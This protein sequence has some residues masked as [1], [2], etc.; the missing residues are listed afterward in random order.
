MNNINKIFLTILLSISGI[1]LAT[2]QNSVTVSSAEGVPGTVVNIDVMLQNSDG[3]TAAEFVFPLAEKQLVYVDGSCEINAE[4]A[5]GH[6]ISAATVDGNLKVYV[7]GFS[8]KQLKENDGRLFSFSLKLGKS[9]ALYPLQPQVIL[10]DAQGEALPVTANEGDV[11]I[12]APQA[13]IVTQTIDFGHV[14]IRSQYEKTLTLRNCGTTAL[15]V[16]DIVTSSDVFSVSERAFTIPAGG[17]K[18]LNVLFAPVKRGAVEETVTV[19]SNAVNGS[20]TARLVADPYSVNELH[21]SAASGIAGEEVTVEL[22]MN[23]MEPIVGLQT[24]FTIP[25]QLEFVEGSFAPTERASSHTASATCSSGKV[26]LLLYS[27]NNNAISGNDGVVATFRL[28][29]AGHSGYYRIAPENTVLSNVALENMTSAVSGNDIRISSPAIDGNSEL[30]MGSTPVTEVARAEY[31]VKNSGSAPLV[32]SSVA[33][34]A[35]GYKV[36]NELP[37]TI[38][39]YSSGTLNV[40]YT[41]AKEGEHSV[42]MNIYSNDPVNIMK[43]VKIKGSIFEPNN[44]SFDGENLQNGNYVVSV[45]LDNY[46]GIVALQMDI[47]WMP[48]M[49]TSGDLLKVSE[50]LGAHNCSITKL[51]EDSYRFIAF[52]FGNSVVGGNSG[53]LFDLTFVPEGGVDYKDTPILI[54]N[55][56]MSNSL[57]Q[58]YTSQLSVNAKASFK[59]FYV[60][61]VC[62]GEIIS[63][64]FQ[65]VG[66]RIVKPQMPERTGYTFSGWKDVPDL[67]PAKDVEYTGEYKVNL[68]KVSYVV[69]GVEFASDS[70]A[71]GSKIVLR[72]APTKEG[73]TFSGWSDVPE[74]M[75]AEDIVIE[76]SFAVNSYKIV[77]KVDGEEYKSETVVYGTAITLIDEPTKE[78][79]T[80]S[81]WSEAPATM[82]AEDI[83][84]EGCFAVNSY[85]VTYIVDG[86]EYKT[87][88]VVFG[89]AITLIDAPTKEG[90][91]F[92]GWSEA[93]ATMPAEDIVIE[94]TFSVNSYKVTYNVDGEEYKTETVVYGSAI[95]LIDAPTKEGHTF[96]GW[97]N[98][99]ETMPAED[100]V[101]EGS[102][103]VNSYKVVYKVDGEEYKSETVVY[104]SA[105]TLIDEPTKEGHTF[106]GWSEAPATMPAEDIT[107][108]GT[109]D[110]N[111]YTITYYVDGEIY[112]SYTLAYNDLVVAPEPPLKD[113]Y[114][115]GGWRDVPQTMPA[116][117][118]TVTSSFVIN[119]YKVTYLVDGEEYQSE[120]VEY[121]SK[122]LLPKFPTKE[123]HT[124]SGWSEAPA[125]M[126]AEDIV[127]EGTFSVNSYKVTYIFDGEEYKTE[128]VVFG[129]AITLIDAPTKEGHT[130]SGWSDVPETMP[131][132]DIV[133]EGT[134]SVNSYKIVY[135]VDG[136]E[137]KSE[138]VVYGSAITLIDEPTKEGHTFSGWS[139]AP[140]TMPAEDIVI[141]GSFAVNS[142]KVTYIVDG[143]EYE[144]EAVV[145]GS[146]ITLIDAPT[147]EGHTF[148]GWSNVPETMPAE[149]IVIEGT[150]SVNSYKVTYIVDG[151]EYASF[152]VEYGAEIPL[153]DEPEKEGYLF[154]GWSEI[155][156]TMPAEDISIEAI[157]STDTGVLDIIEERRADVY[158]IRGVLVMKH[159][160]IEEIVHLPR[161]VYI[162]N[163]VKV[164]IE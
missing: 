157:F 120:L 102:F 127:I 16:T 110:V 54:D 75:P 72:D 21:S 15:D 140:E 100:I 161:G 109:F 121:G 96:S 118:V 28:R 123:G 142:Y 163:G 41:P 137:Y 155:P 107:I 48:E 24:T 146:A 45:G 49:T 158:T 35:E 106:S 114:T 58:D 6:L 59:N 77:Y 30:D 4:R 90:H 135:K 42:A 38:G 112:T 113:G 3:V 117:D 66:N 71:Y 133:I 76:G 68:Y 91:T 149:D 18:S 22:R 153:P 103:A 43:T 138:A 61:F 37:M 2:A 19:V 141:E 95:T 69:N 147:K 52:S 98:V 40:E 124:F 31:A 62:E 1:I 82:P 126:P 143:E 34:L 94:G 164:F 60:R 132:E 29:L 55:V 39:A 7:Y 85:K 57:G 134:F 79:H 139:E 13:E 32:I 70:I 17:A 26:T 97:S 128:T 44:L 111:Y 73:H 8:L 119:G 104:G 14:P 144:S 93:P 130:F 80:F 20:V 88:T 64:T 10:S 150:F 12:L 36:T 23:N 122:I 84:I 83:V 99:P 152:T 53:K 46:T 148:S 56:G 86:E 136:E 131:A 81:G 74:T 125:T 129:T 115:F 25:E 78:G 63:E 145:Y 154:E 50:R 108:I 51:D 101:I 9:P 5:D 160:P 156:E 92:S 67:S 33:F 27:L 89:T 65:A 159:V 151:E 87:E 47:H 105:I 11:T 162:V 116:N